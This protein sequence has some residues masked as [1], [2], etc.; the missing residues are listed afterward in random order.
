MFRS[1]VVST[2]KTRQVLQERQSSAAKIW[3]CF[4]IPV[5][6][7]TVFFGRGKTGRYHE[8]EDHLSKSNAFL[9]LFFPMNTVMLR[10]GASRDARAWLTTRGLLT[11]AALRKPAR[12]ASARRLAASRQTASQAWETDSSSSSNTLQLRD[13]KQLRIHEGKQEM[14]H[15]HTHTRHLCHGGFRD[16][17]HTS[18]PPGFKC[19]PLISEKISS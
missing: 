6:F 11:E 2:E 4:R 5:T 10:L 9:K 7:P 19:Y 3:L 1:A 15:T 13:K 18:A 16:A 12:C 8:D 17:A 14:S